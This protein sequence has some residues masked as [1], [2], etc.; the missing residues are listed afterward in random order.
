MKRETRIF[1]GWRALCPWVLVVATHGCAPVAAR[2]PSNIGAV[3]AGDYTPLL[4]SRRQC[5]FVANM[6]A[7]VHVSGVVNGRQVRRD[8]SIGTHSGVEARFDSFGDS[9]RPPFAVGRRRSLPSVLPTVRTA[10]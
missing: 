8:F 7:G 9:T 1:H 2:L 4:Q 6:E 10:G 3:D 5:Q